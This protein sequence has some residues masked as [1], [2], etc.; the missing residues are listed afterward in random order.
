MGPTWMTR[1]WRYGVLCFRGANFYASC[2]QLL[3]AH[4]LSISTI[5]FS[6]GIKEI[7]HQS[8]RNYCGYSNIPSMDQ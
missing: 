8:I 4:M 6:P 5:V 2:C 1:E 3:W 7:A